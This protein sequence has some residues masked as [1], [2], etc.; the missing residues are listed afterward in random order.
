MATENLSS[1]FVSGN[2][3][4]KPRSGTTGYAGRTVS[5]ATVSGPFGAMMFANTAASS[6]LTAS[7]TETT[8][9]TGTVTL[10]AN[11]LGAGSVI[12]FRAQVIATATNSTDTL[13]VKVKIGSTVIAT[14]GAVDVANNDIAYIEG[15]LIVRTAGASGTAVATGVVGLGAEGTVTAK[16]FKLASTTLD[17]TAAQAVTVSGQWSTTSGSNS[18]RLD[19][20]TVE[21]F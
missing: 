7:S 16:P 15:C 1:E 21:L 4:F 9:S 13:T 6:A 12:R 17:T 18:C 11:N 3:L 14:T 19:V 10:P 2:L 20:F 5:D 8:F